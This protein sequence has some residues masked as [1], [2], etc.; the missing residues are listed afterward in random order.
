M[1]YYHL[2]IILFSIMISC[3]SDDS[4][5]YIGNWMDQKTESQFLTIS[6]TGNNFIVTTDNKK[7]PAKLENSILSVSIGSNEYKLIYENNLKLLIFNGEEYILEENGISS[8]FIG[9]WY[10]AVHGANEMVEVSKSGSQIIWK[11]LSAING[12]QSTHYPKIKNNGLTFKFGE[13]TPFF[14]IKDGYIVEELAPNIFGPKYCKNLQKDS[15]GQFILDTT[16]FNTIQAVSNNVNVYSAPD[17]NSSIIYTM[18]KDE[19]ADY[20]S[21]K[22]MFTS[23]F[24]IGSIKTNE[25]WYKVTINRRLS[26]WVNGCCIKL[27]ITTTEEAGE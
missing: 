8:K 26:G 27:Y 1:K 23:E 5:K 25:A 6:K 13:N 24:Q 20:A 14:I 7:F 18:K 11:Y 10:N 12:L 16:G 3:N 21:F 15:E 19:Y 9:T 2:S 17:L 22:S 4:S